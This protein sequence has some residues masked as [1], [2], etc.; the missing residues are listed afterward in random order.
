MQNFYIIA[1]IVSTWLGIAARLARPLIVGRS[2]ATLAKETG[3]SVPDAAEAI[4]TASGVGAIGSARRT[5]RGLA[6]A[7][8]P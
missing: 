6:Q 4:A 3:C 2:L 8:P 1:G 5:P 7:D